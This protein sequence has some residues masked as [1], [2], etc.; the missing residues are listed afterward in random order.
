MVFLSISFKNCSLS[1]QTF[2]TPG[3]G[4]GCLNPQAKVLSTSHTVLMNMKILCAKRQSTTHRRGWYNVA[5]Q[6]Q[7]L[8]EKAHS[9]SLPGYIYFL[10]FME[11]LNGSNQYNLCQLEF[12]FLFVFL[13]SLSNKIL[14]FGKHIMWYRKKFQSFYLNV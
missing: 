5:L 4:T 13:S 12:N 1:Y 2:S 14:H 6:L 10:K 3:T 9:N 11:M 8:H 7:H